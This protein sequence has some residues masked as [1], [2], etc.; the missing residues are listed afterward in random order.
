MQIIAYLY[1]DPLIDAPPNPEIWGLEIDRVYQDRGQRWQLQKLLADCKTHP[2]DYLLIRR[3]DE[4]GDCLDAIESVVQSLEE[5]DIEII[6]TEQNYSTSQ[7]HNAQGTDLRTN[8][9]QLLQEIQQTQRRRRLTQGHA[10]NRISALPPPGKACYGYRRGKDRYLLDRSTAPVVKDFFD[11]YLL[12]G[13]LRGAVRY[14]EQKYGKKISATTGR[15]W[16]TNPVYRGDLAYQTGEIIPDTHAPILSRSEAAQI[17]RLLRRNRRLP[18][19]TASAPRSLAGLVVC[20]HCQSPTTITRV[21]ARGKSQDYLY[22]RPVSCPQKPKCKAFP[23]QQVLE[24]TIARICEDLPRAVAAINGPNLSSVKDTLSSEIVK[25]QETLTRIPD[26][27]AQGILDEETAVLRE[28]NLRAEI[29]RLREKLDQLP[30]ANLGAI[31]QTVALPQFWFDLS[32]TERRFYF[33]EFIQSIEIVRHDR[34]WSL[35]LIFIF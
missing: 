6:A 11:R 17:D 20:Q 19:R 25:K 1:S 2:P 28:Y 27:K 29:A 5:L 7:L 15:R 14:L 35:Q 9:T 10:R 8:L 16:L 30:P 4:L 21:T 24:K 3:L 32:E 23:Y 34:D 33:R 13:S 26:G 18:P 31:A 22:V 12:F